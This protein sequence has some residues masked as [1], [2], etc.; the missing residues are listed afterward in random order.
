MRNHLCLRLAMDGCFSFLLNPYNCHV[1]GTVLSTM[2]V[3]PYL[4]FTI[5]SS[6]IRMMS[7][8]QMKKLRKDAMK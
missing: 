1:A 3:L 8:S 5:L 4:I 6:L 2:H 7:I